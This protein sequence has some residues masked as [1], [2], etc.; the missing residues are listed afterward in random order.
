MTTASLFQW[1]IL[2]QD[3]P[4]T[5]V[6]AGDRAV[7]VDHLQPT[8]S[9]SEAGYTLEVFREGETLDVI[10]VPISWVTVLPEVWGQ[11]QVASRL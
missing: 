7:V 10:S 9:Q 1:V 5:S 4:N 6:K 2:N 8:Q 3:V 11:F